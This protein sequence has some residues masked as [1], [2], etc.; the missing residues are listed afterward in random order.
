MPHGR[1]VDEAQ[2][3]DDHRMRNVRYADTF[4]LFGKDTIWGI[5]ANNAPTV[6]DPWNTTPSWGWRRSPRPS[7]RR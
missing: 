4:K 3:L 7:P 6:E 5:D 1:A 2:D